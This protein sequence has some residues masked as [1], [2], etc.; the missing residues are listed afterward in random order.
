[1]QVGRV[2]RHLT[3][4]NLHAGAHSYA[5]SDVFLGV[6]E[7][8]QRDRA[9]RHAEEDAHLAEGLLLAHQERQTVLCN[10]S[11]S[12][13]TAHCTG[14]YLCAPE[15]GTRSYVAP[16]GLLTRAAA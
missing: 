4:R 2:V 8:E 9:A 15:A 3:G 12:P 10:L 11:I 1:M 13:L 16:M 14:S 7:C 5:D 6:Q